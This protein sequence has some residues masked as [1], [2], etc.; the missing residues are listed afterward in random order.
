MKKSIGFLLVSTV[1][2]L[3]SCKNDIDL[4][5]EYK[6]T[7]I[8]YCLL[9]PAE[10][11]HYIRIQKAFLIN[12]NVLETAK[13]PDSLRYDPSDL[14]VK[15]QAI[16][17][18]TGQPP[19]IVNPLHNPIIFQYQTG[20]VQDTGVFATE[21]LMI[22]KAD[23]VLNDLYVYRL[24]ITNTKLG[25]EITAE[26]PLIRSFTFKNPNAGVINFNS[27]NASGYTLRW[28]S[29]ANGFVYQPEIILRWQEV[30]VSTGISKPDSVKW[31]ITPKES[32]AI[33]AS[34]P[35]TEMD[36]NLAQNSF[37]QF[38]G[39]NVAPKQNVKR[40]IGNLTFKFYVGTEELN[41]YINVNKPSIG[42]IQEKPVYTNIT[43]GLGIFSGRSVFLRNMPL[44][45][46][47]KDTLISGTYTK[48][49]GFRRN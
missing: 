19:P 2:G 40:I 43:N 39:G 10:G 1:L 3:F 44:A 41:T 34:N 4:T 27:P 22:Y 49:L 13:I 38:V 29:A 48:D 37:Y 5:G 30:D 35:G 23:K 33:E 32:T 42:L 24:S 14:E 9:N 45:E 25:K 28:G 46:P 36:Y 47:A 20:A 8:V 12:G 31:T 26:T 18:N 16:D 15:V 7:P 11:T 17:P 21:G 6:D